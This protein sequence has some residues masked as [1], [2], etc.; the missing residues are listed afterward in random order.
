MTENRLV[1][2]FEYDPRDATAA[3]YGYG[4]PLPAGDVDTEGR[5]RLYG[6]YRQWDWCISKV[7]NRPLEPGENP[8]PTH[9]SMRSEPG[10]KNGLFF[11]APLEYLAEVVIPGDFTTREIGIKQHWS[12]RTKIP[13]ALPLTGAPVLTRNAAAMLAAAR[14]RELFE[15]P[16]TVRYV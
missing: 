9:A 8:F 15:V 14:E 7:F 2:R 3:C 10:F 5:P 11:V 16:V 1:H 13:V 6:Y 12:V 4:I